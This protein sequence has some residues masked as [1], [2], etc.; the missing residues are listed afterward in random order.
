MQTRRQRMWLLIIGILLFLL[1]TPI[2]IL[3]NLATGGELKFSPLIWFLIIFMVLVGVA[4]FVCQVLIERRNEALVSPS[5]EN[6]L[7]LL[8]R[9]RE[10]WIKKKFEPTFDL[11]LVPGLGEQHGTNPV[12]PLPV[13][14]RI[15][16]VYEQG[17]FLLLGPPGSGKTMLL[18]EL[19][20]KLLDS[21]TRDPN[22][23]LPVI[24][25]LAS[26]AIKKQ[27]LDEW[28]VEELHE[29]YDIP[30]KLGGSWLQ[31]NKILPL[32]DGLDEVP[33]LHREEC[34]QKINAYNQVRDLPL[35]LCCRSDDY[36][37]LGTSVKLDATI[38]LEPLTAS[39]I[40][41]YLKQAGKSLEHVR[42]AYHGNALLRQLVTTPLMLRV[43]T[44]T[45]EGRPLGVIL[46]AKPEEELKD[47]IFAAYIER[48]YDRIEQPRRNVFAT[49]IERMFSREGTV[50]RYPLKQMKQSLKWLA[51]QLLLHEQPVFYI[52]RMQPNWLTNKRLRSLYRLLVME[53][54]TVLVCGVIGLFVG[55]LPGIAAG[56]L[57]GILLGGALAGLNSI[58]RSTQ[59]I[60]RPKTLWTRGLQVVIFTGK[61]LLFGIGGGIGYGLF[62]WL[63]VGVIFAQPEG[64]VNAEAGGLLFGVIFGV[65]SGF[66]STFMGGPEMNI[67]PAEMVSWSWR[68]MGQI[69]AIFL[70]FGLALGIILGFY[71]QPDKPGIIV[72]LF[73]IPA[74]ILGLFG[75]L[76]GGWSSQTIAEDH[77]LT[78]NE[79]IRLSMRNGVRTMLIVGLIIGLATTFPLV[80]AAL[81]SQL[82]DL[83]TALLY[84]FLQGFLFSGV[85]FGVIAGLALGLN[86]VIKHSILRLLLHREN[87]MPWDYAS[88]LNYTTECKLLVRNRGG[89]VFFHRLLM[90]HFA[91]LDMPKCPRCGSQDNRFGE[92][93]CPKCG[94]LRT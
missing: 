16:K 57:T 63:I 9:V 61:F 50:T 86:A 22:L 76:I 90:E 89:Y 88:F 84:G 38:F 43:L 60:G 28:I 31:S 80:L 25:E 71:F 6:C 7:R 52:E 73:L 10:S 53:V 59:P 12:S 77:L 29:T 33:P 1:I 79:G 83:L 74:L 15:T 62:L 4:L 68:R 21:A 37:A 67:R 17:G 78:P 18:L 13:G 66:M 58:T 92:H 42:D 55:G 14:T 36:S 23:S 47:R 46:E 69:V 82:F 54:V 64:L 87:E 40:E 75:G 56:I 85:F 35:V 48:M 2:T 27:P 20:D 94:L 45:F 51:Q 81:Q 41:E 72:L 8:R 65:F 91:T 70:G 24:F 5:R 39:Q 32:L 49:Y 3:V 26:W 93:Y 19:T 30:L 44:L 11:D 34:I